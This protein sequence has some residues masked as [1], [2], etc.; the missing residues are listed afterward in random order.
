[1][2]HY[3]VQVGYNAGGVAAMVKEPQNRIEKVTPA[4]EALGGRVEAGTLRSATTTSSS[5]ASCRTTSAPRRSR[6]RSRPA[7]PS[8]RTRPPSCPPT[9]PSRP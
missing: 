7:G 4:I 1:M 8:R 2:P 6:W 3:L 5:S 9:R